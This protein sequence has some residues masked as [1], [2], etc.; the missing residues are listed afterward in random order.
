MRGDSFMKFIV[1]IALG[2][3]A[4][5]A[6]PAISQ[7]AAIGVA[8]QPTVVL[9]PAPLNK[10]TQGTPVAMRLLRELT[11]KDK[12]LK[13]GDRF[14]LE[15]V[16]PIKLGAVTVIPSG[17]RGVGEVMSVRNKGMWG[18]SGHFDGRLMY[19]RVGDRQIRLSGSFDDK[20]VAGGWG[21]AGATLLAAPIL[22][23]AGFFMTGTS[24]KVEAGTI[25]R[26]YL[27]EEVPVMINEADASRPLTASQS[28][29]PIKAN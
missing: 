28:A 27:D 7:T 25:I 2:A 16:D 29:E 9:A 8:P 12:K 18:K 5:Y 3:A 21:A 19:L 23:I 22:P 15:L 26:G 14:D 4:F 24:A 11:T 10:L 6:N 17:T 1:T 20:G 13:V